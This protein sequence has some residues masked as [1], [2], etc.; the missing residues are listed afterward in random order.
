MS[1]NK[2][3]KLS[4]TGKKMNEV[5]FWKNLHQVYHILNSVIK[6]SKAELFGSKKFIGWCNKPNE[7]VQY[8]LVLH[9]LEDMRHSNLKKLEK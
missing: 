8:K 7:V 6:G 5:N 3:I 9:T 2:T 4:S 1:K